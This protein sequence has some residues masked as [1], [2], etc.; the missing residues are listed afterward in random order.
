MLH[1]DSVLLIKYTVNRQFTAMSTWTN[2]DIKTWIKDEYKSNGFRSAIVKPP[3]H[4]AQPTEDEQQASDD[5]R[6]TEINKSI[7][8][9]M[10]K[11]V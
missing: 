9:F 2:K 3:L 7:S 8:S 1:L 6:M 10:C 4:V 11:N 5:N